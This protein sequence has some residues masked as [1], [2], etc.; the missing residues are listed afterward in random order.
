MDRLVEFATRHPLLCAGFVAVAL[1][2]VVWE[3]RHLRRGYSALSP[4]QVTEWINRQDARVID[5]AAV[6]D[7]QKSHIPGALNVPLADAGPDHKEF[8]KCRERALVVYDRAGSLSAG[9]AQKLFKAGFNKIG[10]LEGGLDAW[11]REQLPTV[12]GR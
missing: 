11:I 1:A 10:F 12:R 7:Y 5:L 3:M 8:A 2:W 9:I 4:G 6:N